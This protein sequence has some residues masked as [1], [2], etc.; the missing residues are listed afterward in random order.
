MAPMMAAKIQE[1][2]TFSKSKVITTQSQKETGK[3]R[4]LDRTMVTKFI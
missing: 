4:T 2:K 3:K 1:R